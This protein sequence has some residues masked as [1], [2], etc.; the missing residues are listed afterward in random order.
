MIFEFISVS[1]GR[2]ARDHRLQKKMYLRLGDKAKDGRDG[3]GQDTRLSP[4]QPADHVA[5]LR[6]SSVHV[7]RSV[8]KLK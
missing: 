3:P 2:P 6:K 5:P 8:K 4:G 7:G 1:I